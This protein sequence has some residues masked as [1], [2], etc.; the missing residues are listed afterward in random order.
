MIIIKTNA[1]ACFVAVEIFEKGLCCAAS[2]DWCEFKIY[3]DRCKTGV[4]LR[5]FNEVNPS[6]L[7]HIDYFFMLCLNKEG[8]ILLP[9]QYWTLML[10]DTFERSTELNISLVI[11]KQNAI[12]V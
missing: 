7:N 10:T 4:A 9:N 3:H 6:N 8:Q 11:E 12:I 2:H 1:S 5:T